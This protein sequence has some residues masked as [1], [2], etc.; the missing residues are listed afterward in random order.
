MDLHQEFF[1]KLADEWDPQQPVDR[2][3]TFKPVLTKL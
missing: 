3:G 1:E 2:F